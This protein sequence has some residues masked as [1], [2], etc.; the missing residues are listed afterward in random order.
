MSIRDVAL[1]PDKSEIGGFTLVS[2]YPEVLYVFLPHFF[3]S[4]TSL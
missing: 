3:S 4:L 2:D 1:V